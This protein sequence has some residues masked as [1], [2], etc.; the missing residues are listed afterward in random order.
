MTDAVTSWLRLWITRLPLKIHFFLWLYTDWVVSQHFF[1]SWC[2]NPLVG[3]GLHPR[4]WG[5]FF[6]YHTQD[7]TVG[8]TPLDEWSALCR[9][10]YLTTHNTHNRQTSMPLVGFEPTISAGK[11]PLDLC[12]R[13]RGNW[14]RPYLTTHC[15]TCIH[16]RNPVGHFSWWSHGCHMCTTQTCA[17]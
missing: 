15:A 14:D 16:N 10:L 5:L 13:P 2:D 4:S 9:D 17:L 6:L 12:L 3:L 11:L 7:T 1:F 8:R